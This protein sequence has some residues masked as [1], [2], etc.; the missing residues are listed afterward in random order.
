VTLVPSG[1]GFDRLGAAEAYR[2]TEGD[3][4]E[5]WRP[6]GPVPPGRAVEMPP[7]SMVTVRFARR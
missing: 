3:A 4:G 7:R 6:L 5:H 2:S 1:A